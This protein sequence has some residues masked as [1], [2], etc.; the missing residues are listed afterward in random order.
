MGVR[1]G[2]S[3]WGKICLCGDTVSSSENVG[4]SE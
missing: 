2:L 3:D 4:S 1:L